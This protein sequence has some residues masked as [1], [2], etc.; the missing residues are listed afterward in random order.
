M[1]NPAIEK[2]YKILNKKELEKE[3]ILELSNLKGTDIPD[4]I[5]L[6]N[7][8]KETY[9]I[10]SHSCTI[11]NAKSGKCSENCSFCAQSSFHNT[12]IESYPLLSGAEILEK[13]KEAYNSGIRK[14]GIVTSGRGYQKVTPEL[15]K[16][17]AS[18][19]EIYQVL[20]DLE[21]CLTIGALSE[22]VVKL[23]ADHKVKNYNINFQTNPAKY[24]KLVSTTHQFQEK[25]DTIKYLQKYGLKVCTGGILG[26]GEA[27]EDRIEM[28]Y[29]IKKADVDRIPLNILIPIKGTPLEKQKHL[30]P[31]EI[32]VTFAL[33]RLINPAKTI[34]FTAG[35]ETIMK[36]F[37]ALLMLAGANGIMTGGYL[38]TR[39]RSVKEDSTFLDNMESFK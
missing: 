15:K 14:F 11:V 31:T 6:A 5:S 19:D 1:I 28:A 3:L 20:P 39:G 36:D 17:L 32:A 23:L 34:I 24:E 16:I 4:L 7:K 2:A 13:A 26:L 38:T 22:E 27:M 33:F 29:A 37:Q 35:R 25:T 12:E 8:V 18:V 30:S 21:V 10:K 9:Q